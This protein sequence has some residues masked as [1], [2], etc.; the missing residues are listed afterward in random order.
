M[1]IILLSTTVAFLVKSLAGFGP[2]LITIPV[3]SFYVGFKNAVLISTMSDVVAG[4]I[5]LIGDRKKINFK[6]VSV[7][8]IGMAVGAVCGVSMFGLIPLEV[9]KR[10]FGFA[11]LIILFASLKRKDSIQHIK[12]YKLSGFLIGLGGG[13]LGGLINT[14]GPI[15]ALYLRRVIS[16][17]R[18]FRT[19]L[20]AILFIDALWRIILMST[21]G[22][23][24]EELVE[25]FI[26]SVLPGVFIGIIL[27]QKII[28]KGESK[29]LKWLVEFLILIFAGKLLLM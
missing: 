4:L 10:L 26:T 19:N 18:S 25:M 29:Y 27:G 28:Q 23:V 5:L 22:H 14:N 20:A 1:P 8:Q 9:L 24:S 21:Q 11:M 13:F 7:M 12:F 3:L 15:I 2:A 6:I 16:N 17:T